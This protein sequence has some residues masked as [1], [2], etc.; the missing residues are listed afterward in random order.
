MVPDDLFARPDRLPLDSDVVSPP[1][2]VPPP[3][4]SAAL[5]NQVRPRATALSNELTLIPRGRSGGGT[6]GSRN[7]RIASR[8][9]RIPG[10]APA[11]GQEPLP[12]GRRGIGSVAGAPCS[13]GRLAR[14]GWPVGRFPGN[15]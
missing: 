12:R 5:R 14:S 6:C 3:N 9:Q 2:M 13:T 10:T 1:R 4:R 11:G 7:Q 15:R 8:L